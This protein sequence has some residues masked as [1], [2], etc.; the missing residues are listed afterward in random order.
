M[1]EYGPSVALEVK[2]LDEA[3]YIEGIASAFGH[4]DYGND[5]VMRGAYSK[6]LAAKPSVPMLLFH[7]MK[8]PVGRWGKLL[9]EEAGLKVEGRISIKTREGADAYEL[10]KDGALGALSIGYD[11]TR[12]RMDGKVRELHEI[13]LHEVSLVT[14]GM[15]PKAQVLGV[16]ELDDII[17]KLRAGDRLQEREW[18]RLLRKQFNLSNAEAERAVRINLKGQGAP[19]G[20]A[21][22]ADFAKKLRA[23]LIG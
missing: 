13:D 10:A 20:T 8:R 9:E 14:V 11:P 1:R 7:D 18:E 21:N 6:S 4:V 22:P 3:G 23:A 2:N 12:H 15:D 17:Q 5:R 16:K 19:G